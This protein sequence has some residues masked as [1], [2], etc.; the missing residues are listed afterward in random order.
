MARIY[1]KTELENK[2]QQ[3]NEERQNTLGTSKRLQLNNSISYYIAHLAKFDENPEL[4]TIK[5]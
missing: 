4:K 3:L 1:T 5:A 2:V